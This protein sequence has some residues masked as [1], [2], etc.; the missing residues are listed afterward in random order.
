MYDV[1]METKDGTKTFEDLVLDHGDAQADFASVGATGPEYWA[2]QRM[3]LLACKALQEYV[4]A[5][6]GQEDFN[7][8]NE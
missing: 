8:Y 5:L 2:A 6:P 3:Y 4:R 1:V 7:I